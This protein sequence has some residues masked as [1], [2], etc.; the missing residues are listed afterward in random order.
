MRGNLFTATK[1]Q[2]RVECSIEGTY[3]W[4]NCANT[5]WVVCYLNWRVAKM[6]FMHFSGRRLLSRLF[7]E[8]SRSVN[9]LA[10]DKSD[11]RKRA[12]LAEI[13]TCP[14]FSLSTCAVLN[15][16]VRRLC[17]Y[18]KMSFRRR[19]SSSCR[20]IGNMWV[21]RNRIDLIKTL[22]LLSFQDR[23]VCVLSRN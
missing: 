15:C 18:T 4:G 16:S 8:A 1:I 11:S 5:R 13:K 17:P 3:F 12:T 2:F 9:W 20:P 7:A 19:F 23:P 21:A 14:E 10:A 6:N 22:F